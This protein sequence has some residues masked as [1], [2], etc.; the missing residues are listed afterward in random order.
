MHTR[1]FLPPPSLDCVAKSSVAWLVSVQKGM[2]KFATSLGFLC[3][4][5]VPLYFRGRKQTV[6]QGLH[7]FVMPCHS[8][9]FDWQ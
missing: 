6:L 4:A 3:G 5:F 7:S 2:G 8:R 1:A 9:S